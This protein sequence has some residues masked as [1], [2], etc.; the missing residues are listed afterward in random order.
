MELYSLSNKHKG[1]SCY[2]VSSDVCSLLKGL[3]QPDL[4]AIEIA[5]SIVF[6]AMNIK[7]DRIC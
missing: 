2:A 1:A 6:V 7:G 3:G 4:V 5:C